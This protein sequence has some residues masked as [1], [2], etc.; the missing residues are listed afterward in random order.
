MRDLFMDEFAVSLLVQELGLIIYQFTQQNL[1][2]CKPVLSPVWVVQIVYRYDVEC[3]PALYRSNKLAYIKDNSIPK[4]CSKSLKIPKLMKA[5]I[6]I[7]YQLDNYYQN[8]RRYVKSRSD[9]Q[10]LHGLKHHDLSS[11][12]PEDFNHGLPVVPCGLIA[13]SLFND[14]YSF[15][16]GIDEMKVN[17]KNIAG[18]VIVIINLGS[19]FIPS[20]FRMELLSG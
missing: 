2:A 8:H 18:K 7:Y 14:T 10:L 3:V 6:Y 9:R 12:A 15:F 1:P 19:K 4:N 13:W 16:R 20:I 17:R 11:C 5:P